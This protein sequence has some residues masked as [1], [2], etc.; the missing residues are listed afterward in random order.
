MGVKTG[1]SSDAEI[2]NFLVPINQKKRLPNEA[3][4]TENPILMQRRFQPLNDKTS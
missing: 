2:L 3:T 1:N 4:N